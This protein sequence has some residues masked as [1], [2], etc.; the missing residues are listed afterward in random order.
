MTANDRSMTT[1]IQTLVNMNAATTDVGSFTSLPA[2]YR[3]LRIM[4]FE[5][6]VNLTAATLE[7]RTGV[8]GAGSSIA[9][10]TLS[11]LTVSTRFMD[12]TISAVDYLTGPTLTIRCLSPQGAPATVSMMMEYFTLV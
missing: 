9:S 12:A 8:G 4:I 11:P 5:A 3:I 2:K 6:S 7:V 1:P 10:A